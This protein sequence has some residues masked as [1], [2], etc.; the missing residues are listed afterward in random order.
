MAA[1]SEQGSLDGRTVLITGGSGGIGYQTAR[2]LAR[3][4]P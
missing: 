2:V 4:A 1:F 3:G